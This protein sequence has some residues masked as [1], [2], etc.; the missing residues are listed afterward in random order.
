M[1]K[2][3]KKDKSVQS[4]KASKIKNA[5]EKS[6]VEKGIAKAVSKIVTKNAKKK[7]TVT[8]SWVRSEVFKI[9]DS[10]AKAKKH[11]MSYKKK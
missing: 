3:I 7:K 5:C 8:S 11:W 10:I 2:V 9:F 1:V 4:F 6:G